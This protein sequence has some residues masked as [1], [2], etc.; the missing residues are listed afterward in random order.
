MVEAS[1][2]LGFFFVTRDLGG[3]LDRCRKVLG[4]EILRLHCFVVNFGR[5]SFLGRETDGG[6]SFFGG[7][8]EA[9]L[10]MRFIEGCC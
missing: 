2:V 5:G 10:Y 3:F 4:H 9:M 6:S 7:E 1:K 8:K